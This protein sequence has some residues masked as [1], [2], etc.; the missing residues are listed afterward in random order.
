[1]RVAGIIAGAEFNRINVQSFELD[2]NLIERELRE[3]WSKDANLHANQH[4]SPANLCGG[5]GIVCAWANRQF[6]GGSF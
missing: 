2:Q 5:C 1:V 3:Q 6:S 4:I